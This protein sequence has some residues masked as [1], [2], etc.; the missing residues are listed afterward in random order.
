MDL[1]RN[2]LKLQRKLDRDLAYTR[3]V[4]EDW[5]YEMPEYPPWVHARADDWCHDYTDSFSA[6]L[7]SRC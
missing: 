1:L 2:P 6:T 7:R 5:P 3:S 4:Y